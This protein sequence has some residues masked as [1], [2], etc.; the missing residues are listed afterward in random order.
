M[1]LVHL[2]RILSR[3]RFPE[4]FDECIITKPDRLI[5]DP[6]VRLKCQNCGLWSRAIL[7]PPYLFKTYSQ[8]K[9][10]KST[11]EWI[12][13]YSY[14]VLFIFKNNGTKAWKINCS[15][16]S[17][18][19]FKKKRGMELKGTEAGQVREITKLMRRY[20]IKFRKRDVKVFG[21]LPGHCDFCEG[22]H[23]PNRDNPPCKRSGMPSL[24][25][26]GINVFEVL[27]NHNVKYEYP[28]D[29]YL[30]SITAF[31]VK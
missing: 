22:K 15:E 9:T 8:F 3:L 25:S 31:L 16:L 12:C 29:S 7:C 21:F 11:K 13:N 24:E 2:R 30:T 26:I 20:R 1:R 23:C 19:E 17:H 18:V 4:S 28:V 6:M 5:L 14:A 10:L 27:E